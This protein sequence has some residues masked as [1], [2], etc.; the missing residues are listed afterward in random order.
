[1]QALFVITLILAALVVLVP[2]IFMVGAFFRTVVA[3]FRDT[4]HAPGSASRPDDQEGFVDSLAWSLR[5]SEVAN[6]D[7]NESIEGMGGPTPPGGP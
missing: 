2:M 1:M 6:A 4:D 3:A 7:E 5:W